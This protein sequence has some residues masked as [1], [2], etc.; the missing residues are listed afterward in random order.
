M[1]YI[2]NLYMTTEIIYDNLITGDIIL[3]SG[4]D[5]IIS[6]IV[7]IGTSSKWSHIGIVIKDPNFCVETDNPK[8]LFLL[9][10]NGKCEVDIESGKKRLGVQLVDLKK[11]IDDY[12][13]IVVVRQLISEFSRNDEENV[14]RNNL[15]REPYQT[16]FEKTYDYMPLDLIVAFLHKHGYT[17]AD[18]LIDD[19]HTDRVFCSALVAYMF[20]VSGIMDKNTEWSLYTPDYFGQQLENKFMFNTHYYLE[21]TEI[22]KNN[23][24]K[25]ITNTYYKSSICILL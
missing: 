1:Y 8:G 2:T 18:T 3:F 15:F 25:N 17:F 13:G 21:K 10:S 22:L 24:H 20:T 16:V 14:R 7:E 9:N 23:G 5:S 12:D 19:R 4:T 11:M 6:D